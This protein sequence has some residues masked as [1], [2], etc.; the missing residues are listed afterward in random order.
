M[1][2]S[3]IVPRREWIH[4]RRWVFGLARDGRIPMKAM[5]LVAF[6]ALTL[7]VS[8]ANSQTQYRA[9]AH[10]FYQNNWMSGY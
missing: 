9:P 1:Q 10:N 8:A 6:A 7:T 2:G 4:L 5:I 3:Q